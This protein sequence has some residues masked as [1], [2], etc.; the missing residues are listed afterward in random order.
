MNFKP[1]LTAC[2]RWGLIAGVLTMVLMIATYYI[3]MHPFMIAP[4]LDFR[5]LIFGVFIVF[6]LKEFRDYRQEG[7][8]Y[9][10]QGLIGSFVVSLVCTLLCALGLY[11]FGSL[12]PEF[13]SGY[14]EAATAYLKGFPPDAIEQIGKETYERNLNSLPATNLADM[15][16]SYIVKGI[17]I[18]LPIGIILSVILRRTS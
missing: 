9:F 8:L 3:A 1:L 2:L 16:I 6:G 5:L 10:W 18:W 12:V 7:L 15:I 17:L 11:V 14:I 4:F 13:M